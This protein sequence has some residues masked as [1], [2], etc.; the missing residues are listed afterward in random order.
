MIFNA[1]LPQVRLFTTLSHMV[2]GATNQENVVKSD[3]DLKIVIKE[4]YT[5]IY[6]SAIY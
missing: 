2:L 4:K 1:D 5:G 3:K 6:Y